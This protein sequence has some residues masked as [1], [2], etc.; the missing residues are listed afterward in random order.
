MSEDLSE[1][2]KRMKK[3][4][5]VLGLSLAWAPYFLDFAGP[6][7][8]VVSSLFGAWFLGLATMVWQGR[9]KAE[10]KLFAFSILY[11]F[12]LFATLA[13]ERL[14]TEWLV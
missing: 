4:N 2:H 7:Y 10:R 8:G 6:V 13:F 12:V 9:E 5:R 3:R 11:L 1:M 14:I